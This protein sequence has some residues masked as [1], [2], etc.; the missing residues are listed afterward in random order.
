MKKV[1]CSFL[2]FA[3]A[4]LARTPGVYPNARLTPGVVAP[5]TQAEVLKAGYTQDARH[6]PDS[7]KWRVLVR[8]R[9]AKGA[10][11]QAKLSALLKSYEIDHFISPELGGANDITNL[12]PEAYIMSVK[13]ENLGAR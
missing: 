5:V 6:V 8:Y 11:E 3:Q 13:G 10:F 4:L 2:F 1:F 7:V 9:L 12:W